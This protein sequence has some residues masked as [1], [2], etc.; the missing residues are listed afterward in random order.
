MIVTGGLAVS[1]RGRTGGLRL[2]A[3]CGLHL[4]LL[5]NDWMV[6]GVMMKA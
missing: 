5:V 6:G 1:R 4:C 2:T 3:G